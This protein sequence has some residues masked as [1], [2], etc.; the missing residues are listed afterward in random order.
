MLM[1]VPQ[2]CA[3]STSLD[4]SG[5]ALWP[6]RLFPTAAGADETHERETPANYAVLVTV[7]NQRAYPIVSSMSANLFCG[8]RRTEDDG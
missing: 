2:A 8:A 6:R 3:H 1:K 7:W 5:T 4:C